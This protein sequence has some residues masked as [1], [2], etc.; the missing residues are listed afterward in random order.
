MSQHSLPL[1]PVT[2]LARHAS[3]CSNSSALSHPGAQRPFILCL[4]HSPGPCQKVKP[5]GM[6]MGGL[7]SQAG[8]NIIYFNWSSIKQCSGPSNYKG[9]E[10]IP[11]GFQVIPGV[12][13]QPP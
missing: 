2:V 5:V 8:G 6:G 10:M 3:C 1:T 12:G 13:K 9:S 4:R 11:P 7:Q